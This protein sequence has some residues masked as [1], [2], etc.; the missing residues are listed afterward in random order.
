M[1]SYQNESYADNENENEP[2]QYLNDQKQKIKVI[3]GGRYGCAQFI[4]ACG[5]SI[6]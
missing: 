3:P 4:K 6:L 1:D 5:P 2:S